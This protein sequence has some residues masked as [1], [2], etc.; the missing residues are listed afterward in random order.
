MF[1][2]FQLQSLVFKP[3][4]C[5]KR[6]KGTTPSNLVRWTRVFRLFRCSRV[7]RSVPGCSGVPGF[8]TSLQ[9]ALHSVTWSVSWNFEFRCETGFTKNRTAFYFCNGPNDRSGDE[10]CLDGSSFRPLFNASSCSGAVRAKPLALVSWC[11]NTE[12]SRQSCDL[13]VRISMKKEN[14]MGW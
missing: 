3:F 11:S 5:F 10:I 4:D 2:Y 6:P 7:F 8:S 12:S 1:H 13:V 9:Q 14:F